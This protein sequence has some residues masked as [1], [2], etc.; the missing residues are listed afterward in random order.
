MAI[1]GLAMDSITEYVSNLD[2]VKGTEQEA[3]EATV[4]M[5]G[6]LSARVQAL[7]K[8]A[9]TSYRPNEED[10]DTVVGEFNPNKVT[11]L[12]V[13]YGL[14]GWK[15]FQAADGS[16]LKF[17]TI[18]KQH[19][20]TA[21]VIVAPDSMDLLGLGLI[22]ELSEQIEKISTPADIELKD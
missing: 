6:P 11:Y 3:G 2:P 19:G 16:D 10:A 8:D 4:F 20:G 21:Y 14:R 9:A 17:E 7:I 18:T 13:Q 15:N 5:L 12:T 22:R 1:K